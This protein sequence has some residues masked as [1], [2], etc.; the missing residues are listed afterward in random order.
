[1]IFSVLELERGLLMALAKD[2]GKALAMAWGRAQ[3]VALE[4]AREMV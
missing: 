1:L 2:P 3:V 4:T